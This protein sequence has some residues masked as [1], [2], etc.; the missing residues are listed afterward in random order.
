M[1]TSILV[2]VKKPDGS[3]DNNQ[4]ITLVKLYTVIQNPQDQTSVPTSKIT[5]AT[6]AVKGN[7]NSDSMSKLMGSQGN[8]DNGT[9]T[10][11]TRVGVDLKTMTKQASRNFPHHQASK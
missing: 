3:S 10:S 1:T 5:Y 6:A 4:S 11:V 2:L 8:G 7:D 9:Q